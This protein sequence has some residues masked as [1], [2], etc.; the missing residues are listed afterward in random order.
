MKIIG[1]L[2]RKSHLDPTGDYKEGIFLLE[3]E[4][5][6]VLVPEGLGMDGAVLEIPLGK[7][8]CVDVRVA[9]KKDEK[10]QFWAQRVLRSDG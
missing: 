2:T 7:E 1:F 6:N 5:L 10:P 8:I 3:I 4:G 9:F